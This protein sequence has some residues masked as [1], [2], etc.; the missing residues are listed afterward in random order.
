MKS[1]GWIN[2]ASSVHVG[3]REEKIWVEEVDGGGELVVVRMPKRRGGVEKKRRGV[4]V[5]I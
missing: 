2:F 5:V 4:E 1:A 3:N